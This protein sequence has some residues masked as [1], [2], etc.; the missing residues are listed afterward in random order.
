MA[1]E[2]INILKAEVKKEITQNILPF[3]S[4][5]MADTKNSGFV[6]RIDGNGTVYPQ[7][8]KGCV[9]N[10]RIL[11]TFSSAYRV[12]DY[13]EYL[14]QATIAKDYILKY[15]FDKEFGGTYWLIN[16]KGQM[17]DG[18]KQIY[19]Q[20]FVIY[21][22]VEYYRVTE[23]EICLQKAIELFGLI[24]KYSFDTKLGGYFE[25]FN[26]EW[27]EIGDLRLSDKDFNEKKTMNTHL[28]VLEAYTNLYRVWEHDS[29]KQQ[30]IRLIHDFTDRII[31]NKTHHLILFFD[32]HW[33]TK[34][35]I[36]S[37]GHDIEASWLL[38]EAAH[39]LGD[40]TLINK[41][42]PLCLKVADAACE[43]FMPDGSMIYE[44]H[45]DTGH[46]ES[47]RHWWVQ[48]ESVVGFLNAYELS[49]KTVYF[50]KAIA[51]WDYIKA[52]IIDKQKGEWFWS[53]D[54]K[55]KPNLKDDKAGFWKCPYHN[56]RMC[57]E[58]IERDL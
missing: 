1:N 21:A 22:L 10:A 47:D 55:K 45:N 15:F 7:A 4:T 20:A 57:L 42:K 28:H 8:D 5:E 18:K 38:Y 39:V 49:G 43:G 23:D 40:E 54:E 52:N 41:V 33:N 46:I 16:H 13:P 6:G 24:E 44:K 27:G 35:E 12:L 34:S 58:I 48:A 53:A 51:T 37:Y 3:W 56:G 19:A 9:M 30:L 36:V 32:E 14:K 11:W 17:V 50:D 26:R 29:L 2:K 31:D 25:A